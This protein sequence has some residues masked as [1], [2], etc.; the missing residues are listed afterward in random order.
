[1]SVNAII[2]HLIV[3]TRNLKDIGSAFEAFGFSLSPEKQYPFKDALVNNRLIYLDDAYMEFA[4]IVSGDVPFVRKA[5]DKRNGISGIALRS[6]DFNRVHDLAKALD[7]DVDVINFSVDFEEDGSR[8]LGDFRAGI[9]AGTEFPSF[10][11]Q[12][13]EEVSPYD[14]SSFFK[15]HANGA[16]AISGVVFLANNG[17]G[18]ES[19]MKFTGQGGSECKDDIWRWMSGDMEVISMSSQTYHS[20]YGIEYSVDASEAPVTALLEFKVK[21]LA[22]TKGFFSSEGVPFSIFEGMIILSSADSFGFDLAFHA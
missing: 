10:W 21:D 2:D 6:N 17:E 19:L 14:R 4:E 13:I 16:T 3:P 18:R 11:L 9:F 22:M 7:F 8:Y 5:L 12:T 15:P 1:M 20:R